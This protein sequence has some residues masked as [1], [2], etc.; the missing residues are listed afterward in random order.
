MA[1]QLHFVKL[2][3]N[4]EKSMIFIDF[5]MF[6][7]GLGS[8]SWHQIL[9]VGGL[10]GHFGSKLGVLDP[11]WLQVGGN[12]LQVGGSGGHLGFNLGSIFKNIK[13]KTIGFFHVFLS[14]P[15]KLARGGAMRDVRVRGGGSL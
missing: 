8:P 13:K 9:K 1:L 5:S 2:A 6:F 12:G 4:I 7:G 14:P 3:K 10:G 11:R 15:R